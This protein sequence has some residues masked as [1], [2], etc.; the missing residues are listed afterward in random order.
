VLY[1]CE[2]AVKLIPNHGVM[3][4]SRGLA[5]A[6]TGNPKGAIEDFEAYLKWSI[7]DDAKGKRQKWIE[8]LRK[9]ENPFTQKE[10]DSLKDVL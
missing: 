10:L 4:D 8:A 1:A 7:K 9:G 2:N 5:R 3:H 6:L